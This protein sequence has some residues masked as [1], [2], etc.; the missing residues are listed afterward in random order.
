MGL[1]ITTQIGTDKGITSEA[2]IRIS[3]YN[4]SKYGVLFLNYE[5][6]LKQSDAPAYGDPEF[7]LL[8]DE[9]AKNQQIGMQISIQ[10]KNEIDGVEKVD[11]SV[12]T[13]GSVFAYG[14]AKLKEYLI[15]IYG[16]KNIID[17]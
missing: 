9:I 16:A 15:A 2:Y 8:Y 11:M 7:K 4:I 1:K 3:N 12:I 6:F 5:T 14:Y 10:M 17:C 13:N